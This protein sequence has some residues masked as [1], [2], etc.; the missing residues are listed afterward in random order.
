MII[1]IMITIITIIEG[2]RE[3]GLQ[4][5]GPEEARGPLSE[6]ARAKSIVW[7]GMVWYGMVWYSILYYTILY[8]TIL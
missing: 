2:L 5:G 1:T 8:Y 3:A 6:A 4:G 7:Y